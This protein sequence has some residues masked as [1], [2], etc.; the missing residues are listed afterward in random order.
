MPAGNST[1][2]MVFI[3]ITAAGVLLQA[4]VLL[5][6]LFG[7]RQSERKVMEK[8]DEIR[9]DIAPLLSSARELVDE[10]GPKIRAITDNLHVASTHL[11]K[12][13]GSTND[14]VEAMTRRTSAAVEEIT[15]K[16][17][18]AAE[19]ITGRTQHQ[20]RRVDHM[21]TEVL[22]TV[23]NGTRLVQDSIM[24]PMRQLGGWLNA[25]RSI[26][27]TFRRP[28]RRSRANDENMYI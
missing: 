11:R 10:N 26:L 3:A 27:D 14:A 2:L 15:N 28:E 18:A 6:I 9:D 13:V 16:A 1:L 24:A 7:A 20:V 19:E 4:G 5:A 21:V 25:A 8:I 17:R 12:Q 23:A 22:D